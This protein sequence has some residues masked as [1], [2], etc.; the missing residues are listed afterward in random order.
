MWH[1]F[2]NGTGD[3]GDMM[4]MFCHTSAGEKYSKQSSKRRISSLSTARSQLVKLF[5]SV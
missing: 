4:L 1:L 3:D 5:M 2:D